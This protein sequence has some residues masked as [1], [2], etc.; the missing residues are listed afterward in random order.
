M[1]SINRY[2]VLKATRTI[3][4][5]IVPDFAIRYVFNQLKTR[6]V[7]RFIADEGI[8]PTGGVVTELWQA[9][10]GAMIYRYGNGGFSLYVATRPG[11]PYDE[12]SHTTNY[13]YRWGGYN[14]P[15]PPM[16]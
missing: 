3:G 10:D 8:G 16:P 12:I 11:E 14:Q 9:I 13:F 6:M 4:L 5:H 15:A 1:T 2:D 7:R